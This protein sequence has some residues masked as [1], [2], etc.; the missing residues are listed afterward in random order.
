MLRVVF[1]RARLDS[2]WSGEISGI[3]F[4]SAPEVP[5]SARSR[6]LTSSMILT[7]S[8]NHCGEEVDVEA[9]GESGLDAEGKGHIPNEFQARI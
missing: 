6:G 1:G 5:E 3:Q 2:E 7:V 8:R 4:N 9:N